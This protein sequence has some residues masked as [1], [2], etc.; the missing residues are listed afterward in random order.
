MESVSDPE[1]DIADLIVEYCES[2]AD[3]NFEPV[4]RYFENL[5]LAA[6][7]REGERLFREDLEDDNLKED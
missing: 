1:K 7:E 5:I 3:G 4:H 6:A 2:K